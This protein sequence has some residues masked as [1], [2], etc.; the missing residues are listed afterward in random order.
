[1]PEKVSAIKNKPD[2]VSLDVLGNG[3]VMIKWD[4]SVGADKYIV[5]RSKEKDSG[6][7]KVGTVKKKFTQF[8][9]ETIGCEGTF[10]YKISAWKKG[11]EGEKAIQKH[12]DPVKAEVS[13][14]KPPKSEAICEA[15]NKS[16]CFK[17]SH[18]EDKVNGY[19][20][21]RRYSFM[22]K[23]IEI[24]RVESNV[25]EYTDTSAVA[26]QLYYY[27]VQGYLKDESETNTRY[28]LASEELAL[29]CLDC[30]KIMS[31]KCR[32]GRKVEF[33][34]RLTTGADGYVLLHSDEE[35]GDYLEVSRTKEEFSLNVTDVGAKRK[36]F[37]YYKVACVKSADG[38]EFLGP[39]TAP[40]Q[41]KYKF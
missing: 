32:H 9:D 23:P 13:V 21:L 17:W 20:V 34:I 33:S 28:G 11:P 40:V 5:R 16:I 8:L 38:S 36:K 31:V 39:V 14:I 27:S 10:W 25:T 1:M 29:I 3:T 22:D 18:G 4:M 19:V 37:G 6:Y 7:E 26:G 24:A 12:S 15:K 2:I 30:P 41:V 35:N